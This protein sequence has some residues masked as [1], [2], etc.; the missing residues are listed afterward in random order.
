MGEGKLVPFVPL[1]IT[2]YPGDEVET[3]FTILHYSFIDPSMPS[4]ALLMG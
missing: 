2:Y 3:Y 1:P 4:G